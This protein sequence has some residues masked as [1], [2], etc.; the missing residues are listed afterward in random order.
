MESTH[1][2]IIELIGKKIISGYF[3]EGYI[4]SNRETSG[5][6]FGVSRTAIREVLKILQSKGLIESRTKVGTAVRPKSDWNMLDPKVLEWRLKN[7]L[8]NQNAM[9]ELEEIRRAFEPKAAALAAQYHNSENIQKMMKALRG[10][11]YSTE[12]E[13]MAQ[14]DVAFH[15]EIMKATNNSLYVAFG[16]LITVGLQNLI[17]NDME[18]APVEVELWLSWHREIAEAI[19]QSNG[20]LA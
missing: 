5:E 8:Q 9:A 12:K 14:C 10:M 6:D 16:D 3:P 7:P 1:S 18:A 11:A 13:D 19:E 4:F 20:E 15:T 17:L 2:K